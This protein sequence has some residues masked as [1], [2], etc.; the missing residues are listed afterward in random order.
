[1]PKIG[2]NKMSMGEIGLLSSETCFK[3]TV[4]QTCG[5]G[6]GISQQMEGTG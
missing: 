4:I 1:M 2:L 5:L 6:A 3:T